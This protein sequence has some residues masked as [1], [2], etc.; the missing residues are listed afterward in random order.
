MPRQGRRT[1]NG[2]PRARPGQVACVRSIRSLHSGDDRQPIQH[3]V[4]RDGCARE[5]P[6]CAASGRRGAMLLSRRPLCPRGHDDG[7][8]SVG[9]HVGRC[10]GRWC[11]QWRCE[12]EPPNTR[13][14]RPTSCRV[15]SASLVIATVRALRATPPAADRIAEVAVELWSSSTSAQDLKC[16]GRGRAGLVAAPKRAGK[17]AVLAFASGCAARPSPVQPSPT[18]FDIRPR[19]WRPPASPDGTPKSVRSTAVLRTTAGSS[20]IRHGS[21]QL[22]SIPHRA[23]GGRRFDAQ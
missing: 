6:R 22:R 8:G 18:V 12:H 1:R 14:R 17:A 23:E 3:R 13:M 10:S 16:C 9:E 20:A 7:K 15:T 5:N 4:Q 11:A 21:S 19:K 2:T